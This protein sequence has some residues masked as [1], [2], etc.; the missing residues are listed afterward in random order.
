MSK[1]IVKPLKGLSVNVGTGVFNTITTKSIILDNLTIAGVFENNILNNVQITNSQ[2]NNTTIGLQNPAAGS[3]TNLQSGNVGAGYPVTFYGNVIGDSVTWNPNNSTFTVNGALNIRDCTAIS[4]FSI[5]KGTLG[6][7]NTKGLTLSSSTANIYIPQYTNLNFSTTGNNYLVGSGG[8]LLINSTDVY[9]R[10]PIPFIGNYLDTSGSTDRGIQFNYLNSSGNQTLG[11]FGYKAATNLFTFYTDATNNNEII[12]GNLGSMQFKNVIVQSITINS[13]GSIDMSCGNLLNVST[14]TGC[15]GTLNISSGNIVLNTSSNLLFGN[16][17]QINISNGNLALSTFSNGNISLNNGLLVST[18]GSTFV[19]NSLNFNSINS[20]S[21]S[22]SILNTNGN[23]LV[24]GGNTIFNSSI[25]LNN[26]LNFGNNSSANINFTNGN[27]SIVNSFGNI[28]L[29]PQGTTGTIF[30]PDYNKLIFA[31]P[32]NYIYGNQSQ[33]FISSPSQIGITSPVINLNGNVNVIG[34]LNALTTTINSDVYI[35]PLGTAYYNPITSITNTTTAGITRIAVSLPDYLTIGNLVTLI[36]PN[37]VPAITGTYSVGNL[38]NSTTFDIYTGQTLTSSGNSGTVK[39]DLKFDQG[40]DVGIQVDYWTTTNANN[41]TAGS[42]NYRTGFFGF[43]RNTE[44]WTFYHDGTNANDVFT[45]TL[46]DLQ[47][48]NLYIN[49]ISA[50]TL[51]GTLTAGTQGINGSNFNISG[52]NINNTPIGTFTPSTAIFTNVSS[53]NLISTN[54]SSFNNSSTNLTNVNLVNTNSTNLNIL[55]TNISANSAILTNSTVSNL[56]SLNT[57]STNSTLTNSI[58]TNATITN[59]FTVNDSISNLISTNGTVQNLTTNFIYSNSA[60]VSNLISTNISTVN[61]TT[62]NLISGS[63]IAINTNLTNITSLNINSL[64]TNSTNITSSN[65]NSVNITS[66]NINSLNIL[67]TNTTF[68]NSAI[69]NLS[70]L[71]NSLVNINSTNITTVS[72]TSNFISTS[73]LISTNIT[74]INLLSN[75]ISSSNLFSNN[76]TIP[77]LSSTNISSLNLNTNS[78]SVSNLLTTNISINNISVASLITSNIYGTNTTFANAYINNLILSSEQLIVTGTNLTASPNILTATTFI[79]VNGLNIQTS[80]TLPNS[81]QFNG[82][83]K[84]LICNTIGNLSTYTLHVN[85]LTAP[86]P[87]NTALQATKI[88]FKRQ[89]Q[90]CQLFWDSFTNRW[91]TFPGGI[92]IS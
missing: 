1:N 53:T 4:D 26:S 33:L 17:A 65:I 3:F 41:I 2:I 84:T 77:N 52:G 58:L 10:D 73:N 61:L 47:A 46:G 56:N 40:K 42:S 35:L 44:R 64:N 59:L 48:N 76:A 34:S 72:L 57:Y 55:V 19:N 36:S 30:I 8:S 81:G 37:S 20:T 91:I 92:N 28:N 25:Q 66:S 13:G 79:A 63:I 87:L 24:S 60:S 11:F 78:A 71:N 74:S 82:Q 62:S 22:I 16:N 70:S 18:N 86:N 43:K 68:I 9:F 54:I 31:N 89:G 38:I 12:T 51:N 88:K 29:T 67:S 80:G 69:T 27:L 32:A 14:I 75:N 45:G 23:L 15:G 85:N 21:S 90:S 7:S 5:C 50:F 49:G 83:I 6:T 39:S